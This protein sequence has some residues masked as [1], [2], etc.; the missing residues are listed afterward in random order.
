[1]A[2][3]GVTEKEERGKTSKVILPFTKRTRTESDFGQSADREIQ[4][5]KDL[6]GTLT[7]VF[8]CWCRADPCRTSVNAVVLVVCGW[9]CGRK[10][11][12]FAENVGVERRETE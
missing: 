5:Q 4:R 10:P 11:C 7:K 8:I 2:W 9:V 3:R 1:M 12:R 6:A